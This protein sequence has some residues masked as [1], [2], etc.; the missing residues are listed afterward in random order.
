M[1]YH[2][3][4]VHLHEDIDEIKKCTAFLHLISV[5]H[6]SPSTHKGLITNLIQKVKD[7]NAGIPTEDYHIALPAITFFTSAVR[8]FLVSQNISRQILADLDNY[9]LL[10]LSN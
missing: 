9:I 3:I 4:T 2:Y 7:I 5:L 8:D 6:H 10:R 1:N